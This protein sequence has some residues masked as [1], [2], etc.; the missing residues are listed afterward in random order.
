[1]AYP[2]LDKNMITIALEFDEKMQQKHGE[3]YRWEDHRDELIPQALEDYSASK[4]VDSAVPESVPED[5]G[6]GESSSP[7]AES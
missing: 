4:T 2:M 6:Q 5:G 7:G 3:D 1:M